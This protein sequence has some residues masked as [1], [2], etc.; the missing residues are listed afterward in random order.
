MKE[1]APVIIT[2]SDGSHS[3]KLTNTAVTFHST[4]GA[5]TESNHIFMDAGFQY[6]QEHQEPDEI[7]IFEM[8]FGTGLNALLTAIKA[9]ALK[10]KVRYTT[11]DLF[12]LNET[13]LDQLNYG[14]RLDAEL[15]YQ[16]IRQ[17][18]WNQAV[19]ING[20]FILEKLQE[21]LAQ[22]HSEALFDLCF[23]D[24]FA[25]DDQPELWTEAIFKKIISRMK[26][27]GV[28]TTYCSKSVVRKALL[29]AGFKVEKLKGPP[30]KREMVRA[31]A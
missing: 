4:F 13:I 29:Q 28:L 2:T 7:A 11:L 25:P 22:W 10:I 6:Y 19:T 5:Y 27:G 8:G 21:D 20:Y 16:S 26:R 3:V 12:P 30:G 15:L 1:A 9:N 17:A 23:F 31:T 14:S 18:A 24:A